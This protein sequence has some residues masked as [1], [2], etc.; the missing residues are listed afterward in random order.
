MIVASCGTY[1][2]FTRSKLPTYRPRGRIDYQLLYIAAGKA[3]F[4]FEEDVEEIVTAGH[5]VLYRPREMQ[6]YVYYWDDQTEVFWVHF[7]GNDVKQILRRYK[8]P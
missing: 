4:F 3:H 2:L 6:K 1:R 5:M 7:T 8:L